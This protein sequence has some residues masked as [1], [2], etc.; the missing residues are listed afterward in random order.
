MDEQQKPKPSTTLDLTKVAF[1][2]EDRKLFGIMLN[3][4]TMPETTAGFNDALIKRSHEL[5][6]SP[7][8]GADIVAEMCKAHI[9]PINMTVATKKPEGE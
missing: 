1:P 5:A 8:W 6:K 9:L 4:D 7:E 2:P 3:T